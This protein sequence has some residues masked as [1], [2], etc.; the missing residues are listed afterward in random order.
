M[1]T[2]RGTVQYDEKR[3]KNRFEQM[4]LPNDYNQST[5]LVKT[6]EKALLELFCKTTFFPLFI[7]TSSYHAFSR[8]GHT[9]ENLYP[10]QE[11]IQT[12]L[13]PILTVHRSS[14]AILQRY[15][16][17]EIESKTVAVLRIHMQLE[18]PEFQETCRL[19]TVIYCFSSRIK[20]LPF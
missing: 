18:V 16:Q 1:K 6:V 9:Y 15:R 13:M 7:F 8:S 4:T 20:E 11:R 3:R 14:F 17:V 10:Y 2:L 19:S 5:F 12:N